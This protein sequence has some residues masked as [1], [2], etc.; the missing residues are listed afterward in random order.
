MHAAEEKSLWNEGDTRALA[1]RRVEFFIGLEN[2]GVNDMAAKKKKKKAGASARA[3]AAKKKKASKAA[4]AKRA[5]ARKSKAKKAAKRL[6]KKAKKTVKAAARKA[7][8]KKAKKA[9]TVKRKKAV[10]EGDYAASKSFLKDQSSFVEKNRANIPAMGQAAE[11]ALDGPEGGALRD[12]EAAGL[13]RS[14][15]TF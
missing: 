13:A 11:E 5:P 9:A 1:R 2:H 7:P 8:A 12:A 3:G 6:A 15:D 4:K 14:R 10:G